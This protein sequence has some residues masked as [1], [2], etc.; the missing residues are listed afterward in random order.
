M[1]KFISDYLKEYANNPNPQYAI[2]LKGKWGCGKT[3]FIKNWL[4]N[5]SSTNNN[6]DANSLLLKPI[7]I[8]LYG[9]TTISEICS[10]LDREIH[11]FFYSKTGKFIAQFAKIAGKVVLRTSID[12]TGDGQDDATFSGTLDSLAVFKSNN[13]IVKGVKFIIFDDIERCQIEM[14]QLLGF[15][16]Y[17][18]EHC[19]C[20]VVIIGDDT[21]LTKN[22]NDQLV[23]FREKT[24]GREFVIQPDTKVAIDYFISEMPDSSFLQSKKE[25]ILKCFQATKYENLRVLRQCLYDYNAQLSLID[26]ALIQQDN[27]FLHNLLCSFIAVY[28]EYNNVANHDDIMNWANNNLLRFLHTDVDAQNKQRELVQKYNEVSKY[29]LSPEY[30]NAIVA[31]ITTGA[32]LKD[33]LYERLINNDQV[34]P[35]WEKLSGFEDMSND[36]FYSVYEEAMTALIEN[37]ITIPYQIGATISYFYYLNELRIHYLIEAHIAL[38][39]RNIRELIQ[40]ASDLNDLFQIRAGLVQG[41]GYIMQYKNTK[42]SLLNNMLNYISS[43]V[44]QKETE[45]P[46]HMQSALRSLTDENIDKLVIIDDLPYPDKSSNYQLRAIF[47]KE[48]PE[49]LFC[50]LKALSNKGKNSFISF[51]VKHYSLNATYSNM[52]NRYEPDIIVLESLKSMIDKEAIISTGIDKYTYNNLSIALG[53]SIQRCA[54]SVQPLMY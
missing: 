15:I 32:S 33:L 30:L 38:I 22:N 28:A 19:K 27:V 39:K 48:N 49:N 20:H 8:S 10:A 3:F 25:F 36:E 47:S 24:I 34:L 26:K 53:C 17:F 44:K 5:Y 14:K 1:N 31:Y 43:I 37:R 51:L 46:D 4:K 9:L 18:V 42:I 13:D 16:N 11:P 21:H 35:S 29:A 2:M 50:A 45:L 6:E 41:C 23:E 54:G 40:N 7:Y 12:I 52:D